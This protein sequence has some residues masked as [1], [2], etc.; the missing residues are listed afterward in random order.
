MTQETENR[1][2]RYLK[3]MQAEGKIGRRE[4]L[5]SATLLGLSATAAYGFV[6]QLSGSGAVS[7]AL[8]A[9]PKGGTVRISMRVMKVDNPHIF[10]WAEKSNVVRQVCQYLTRTGYDN[11]TRPY[12]L[13]KWEVSDDLRT[14]TLHLRKEVK[15]HNGRAFTADDVVWNF[16]HVLDPATGS[17]MIGLLKGYLM[18]DQA[19]ALWDANAI[20]KVDDRTVR[21]NCKT[22]QLAVPEHLFHYPFLIL[23]PEEGGQFK[24]GSNGTGPF[25]LVQHDIG[26]KSVFKAR[27]DYWGEGPY[28]DTLEFVDLGGDPAADLTAL[29]SRQVDGLFGAGPDTL[30]GLKAIDHTQMYQVV[31]AETAVVRGKLSEKPFQ[32]PRVRKALRLAVDPEKILKVSLGPLG[33]PGE[34]HHVC[35]IHPEYA[36]LPPMQRDVAK[37]RSLLAE[38]GYPDGVDLEI[39]C[40]SDVPW[41][42]NGVQAMVQ[43]WQ[44]AGI[45]VKIKSMP[46]ASYWD[47]WDKVPFGYTLWYHRPLGIMV[48]GLA[49]RSG[50]PWNESGYANAEFDKL[51]NQ[52]E[53]TLDVDKRREVMAKICEIMQEDGPIVQPVW[54]SVFTFY[55]KRVMGFRMHPSNYIFGEELAIQA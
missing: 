19:T 20:E 33:L 15:W 37:A 13:E 16:K 35:P 3:Q 21:L 5:R 14:W 22:P 39:A 53:G 51:L 11:V 42:I 45:R 27:S 36:K 31:T 10:D 4:F 32:D 23:D 2:V 7:P 25:D 54:R 52:A 34:H 47:V 46:S 28:L 18:N 49:Y 8:A 12:L 1:H 55:D 6:G 41:Q 29:T 44:E 38:A 48:L 26:R 40:A 50:A 24:A 43:Q 9:M 30:R 17:S